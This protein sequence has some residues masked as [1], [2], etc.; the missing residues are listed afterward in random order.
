[1]PFW[2]FFRQGRDGRALLVQPSRIPHRISKNIFALGANEFLAMLEGKIRVTPFLKVQSGKK[3]CEYKKIMK[4]KLPNWSKA[5]QFCFIIRAHCATLL[6]RLL[7]QHQQKS[8]CATFFCK[9]NLVC[10]EV[11]FADFLQF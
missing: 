5:T 1:M 8:W 6:E 11:M 2:Q 10:K 7:L 4:S 9:V 3:K